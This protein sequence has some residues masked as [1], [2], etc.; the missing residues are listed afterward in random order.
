MLTEKLS[1]VLDHALSVIDQ[2]DQRAYV[3]DAAGSVERILYKNI[4]CIQK[5]GK[6]IN[7]RHRNGTCRERKT[8]TEVMNALASAE[9]IYVDKSYIVN[10]RQIESIKKD[11]L[12]LRDGSMVRISRPHH[13]PRYRKVR[14]QLIAYWRREV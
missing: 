4:I 7:L 6:Y 13:D 12:V 5:D 10:L 11:Q 8:L 2:I 1:D 9:F 14:E 3:V